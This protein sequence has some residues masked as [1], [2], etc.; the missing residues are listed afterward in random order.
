MAQ[1]FRPVVAKFHAKVNEGRWGSVAFAIP[2]VLKMQVPLKRFWNLESFRFGQPDTQH[3]GRQDEA[4][5]GVKLDL[6]NE[7]I[8]SPDFWAQLQTLDQLFELVRDIFEWVESC[9]CHYKRDAA[10]EIKQRWKSCPLRGRRLSEICCGE[11]FQVVNEICLVNAARL[12]LELP[13]DLSRESRASCLLDF[14]H[15]RGH[16]TF[17]LTLKNAS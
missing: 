6:V 2:E 13:A 16:L 3:H 9:P 1:A 5:S 8:E 15:G 12:Y 7:A 14:E 11:L 17:Q 10:P 4:G